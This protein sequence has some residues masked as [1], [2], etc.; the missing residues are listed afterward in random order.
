LDQRLQ[1]LLNLSSIGLLK[2]SEFLMRARCKISADHMSDAVLCE[3]IMMKLPTE[4]QTSLSIM[5]GGL[6][7]DFAVAADNAMHCFLSA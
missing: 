5:L 3:I 4:V 7:D 1:E 6:L 2:P